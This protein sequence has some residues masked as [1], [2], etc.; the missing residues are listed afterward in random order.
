MQDPIGGF[1]TVLE[2]LLLYIKTA[3]ATQY[4]TL[5]L[6][7]E[8]L[9]R[10]PGRLC[11]EPWL[12]PM[13]TYRTSG[14]KLNDL[15]AG[16]LPGFSEAQTQALKDF[17]ACGLIGDYELHQ[18]QL[19]MLETVLSGR[20]CIV[21]AG[22]GSGKTESFLLP[23]IA[24]IVKDSLAWP[25]TDPPHAR[26]NDWWCNSAWLTA[27]NP[28][29][30]PGARRR[31]L[32]RPLR[33]PQREHE[34]RMPGVR[35]LILYPMN[36]LVEDQLSRL[37]RAL[38]SPAA[39]AWYG[40]KL[41]GNRIYFGRYNAA[42][43]L[44][45]HELNPPPARG[46]TTPNRTKN[47]KLVEELQSIQAASDCAAQYAAEDEHK[48][49]I[50]YFFPRL[51]GSEMRCR[52]D[53]QDAPPDILVTNFSML[54]IMLMR[55]AD[56]SIFRLTREWLQEDGSIF[57]LVID[58]LHLYRGT[59]GTE[60]AYLLRQLLLRL[61][62]YPGH[63]KLRILGSSAS[64]EPDDPQS[65]D[66]LR[67]FF[68]VDWEPTQIIQGDPEELPSDAS[69]RLDPARF[70]EVGDA[71]GSNCP[72]SL[73]EACNNLLASWGCEAST[74]PVA[75]ARNAFDDMVPDVRQRIRTVTNDEALSLSDFATGLFQNQCSQV[76]RSAVRGLLFLGAN[77]DRFPRLR[78]HWFFRN[79]EGLWAC[80]QPGC[81]C[82][83]GETDGRTAGMLFP[84]SRILCA[85]TASHRV[86]ELLYCEQCGTTLFGGRRLELP[87]NR[88]W[89]LLANDPDLEGIPDR[90]A[91]TFLENRRYGEYGIFWPTGRNSLH[92]SA[93]TNW[94]HLDARL[95]CSW[96]AASFNPVTGVL[97]LGW[98]DQTATRGYTYLV[99]GS[100]SSL[101]CLPYLCPCCGTDYVRRRFRKSPIRGF[102][103]GFSKMTQLLS[104]ELMY[105]VDEQSRK[106]VVFSDSR[107][108]A[109]KLANGVE[110]SHYLD[111]VREAIFA[112]LRLIA[113]G[114]ATLAEDIES[115]GGAVRELAIKF[116][117]ENPG[118]V[119][120]LTKV[121]KTARAEIPAGLP[122]EFEEP[123]NKLKSEALL[124]LQLIA[125]RGESRT[126]P[127]ALLFEESENGC[128][129]G[130]LIER[131]RRL[132]VNPGGAHVLYQDYRYDDRWHRWTQFF[133]FESEAG[134]WLQ[135]RPSPD[136]LASRERLRARVES[137]IAR[138]MF[139]RL[140]FGFESS[141][142]GKATLNL[143]HDTGVRLAND[144]GSTIGDFRNLCDSIVRI[145][146]D[147]YRYRQ[148]PQEFVLD[149]WPDWASVRA[150]L[151]GYVRDWTDATGLD[152][153]A[154]QGAL[155]QALSAGG[156]NFFILDMRHLSAKIANPE[157]PVWVCPGCKRPHLHF[158][159]IC[160]QCHQRVN[161]QPND[162]CSALCRNNY[163]SSEASR[164]RKPLRL[165]CEELTAQS[166]DQAERQR[167]F[168]GLVISMADD[169]EVTEIVDTIDIL[170]V[171]TT[172]EVGVDIGNLQA[173]ALANMPPMRFN[174]Q[175]RAGRAGRRGQAFSIVMTLCRGRSH[176]DF[177]FRNPSRITRDRPPVPFLSMERTEI[178]Q[179]LLAKECLRQAFRDSGI[180]WWH[181]PVP[182]DSHGEFGEVSTWLTDS[183]LTESIRRWLQDSP[184][185]EIV[186]RA[187]VGGV[188]SYI[189]TERMVEFARSHLFL[190]VSQAAANDELNGAG[191]AERLAE[192]AVLPMFGMPSRT[193]A[194]YHGISGTTP[195]T[196]ERD[197]DLA[198]TEFAPGAERTKD[199]RI[200]RPI[201]FTTPLILVN[202]TLRPAPGDPLAGRM[203]MRQCER[204]HYIRASVE[205]PAIGNCPNCNCGPDDLPVAFKTFRFAVPQA[206]RTSLGRG[207]DSPDLEAEFRPTSASTIAEADTEPCAVIPGTN[208]GTGFRALGRIY[209]LN[210]RWNQLFAGTVGT[211]R[212]GVGGLQLTDQ[213]IDERYQAEDRLR[214]MPDDAREQV[215]LA[216]PKTTDV[217]RIQ[218][219]ETPRG[220]TL[221]LLRVD[222]SMNTAVK[223]A[224]YSA[225][226]IVRSLVAEQLDI[227]PEELNISN[228]RAVTLGDESPGGEIVL[229][230]HLPNGSGFV[231]WLGENWA[232]ILSEATRVDSPSD[233]FI[234]NL[235][236]NHHRITCE[237]S[238]YDC[239]RQYRNMSYHG[240]LDWRLGLNLL[241][242]L[243]NAE[244]RA[245]LDNDFTLPDLDGWLESA[246]ER[247]DSFCKSFPATAATYG[248]LP[249]MRVGRFQVVV[250][251]PLWDPTQAA[252]LLEEAL[253]EVGGAEARCLDS[254]NLLR[255]QSWAYQSLSSS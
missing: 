46:Q 130:Y 80:T 167:H 84:E 110:R 154:V 12:E 146:G 239:L 95:N 162:S 132:G 187:L 50:I 168:R 78:F 62:L 159:I 219:G 38:D 231:R 142:L 100:A 238:G 25:S 40:D 37:R 170:C 17:A 232:L 155:L 250:I 245:G 117:E 19:S 247:R 93:A 230:D 156:I 200:H 47:E 69:E 77:T 81:G 194:L 5:E 79:V 195:L 9:L 237:S 106:L 83:P 129:L 140:Y 22:T 26:L 7:R 54:S 119:E 137:E 103:T 21:T 164:L 211:A 107:D 207:F 173:V 252:G 1:D 63:P 150:R 243:A 161:S 185:V 82:T 108:E 148:E 136:E 33:V 111:L 29:P 179:R 234:G 36:A 4:S 98:E 175:Q 102:R 251:H 171:T 45:G 126:V 52:W 23:V 101:P 64:L 112:E 32:S 182:P 176:D 11:Q 14:T 160:T 217:L 2:S 49:D 198:I 249:G 241:R 178:A 181:A 92:Q 227:D 57:H 166:D 3:F 183:N 20:N 220:L 44:A 90:Q 145:L 216:A 94:T 204:C 196:I 144:C 203:W 201:G 213:W 105:V 86:L 75:A 109:A 186:A 214:F 56:D 255:R 141:G 210:T 113:L 225:A 224:Y 18:H 226:F 134:R 236:S 39:R 147:L 235:T 190:Q 87:M 74:D 193:R 68:G 122:P 163:Y 59:A 209:R 133:D 165:H 139:G 73:N 153:G 254:F 229:S 16:H 42:T 123:L 120:H 61:D 55:E 97:S 48:A 246:F 172:M 89:E 6:E 212:R 157:D 169:Q 99:F 205:E 192:G 114:Q 180:R 71:L 13:P 189:Q 28:P 125:S 88:G 152:E 10:A 135:E 70:A 177:Y 116:A 215:A 184:E 96:S 188:P 248:R 223:A 218:P 191:L 202:K 222:G 151:R 221:G 8:A 91:A 65:L 53:M 244:F 66:Y 35:A 43:P 174:Y 143:S 240:L 15:G 131:F 34:R 149:P 27:L 104:K 128:V 121:I 76:L 233:S 58:E 138:V 85:N 206:F 31:P 124:Q 60:V 67:D 127:L 197:L 30:Q 41:A 242:V 24:Q 118:S 115:G 228:V 253:E 72:E 208:S 51:D 199:K 158:P